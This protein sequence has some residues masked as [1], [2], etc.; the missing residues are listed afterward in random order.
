[1]HIPYHQ[2]AVCF[3]DSVAM[4]V[5]LVGLEIPLIHNL[6]QIARREKLQIFL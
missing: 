5:E 3:C 4:G 1:M 6:D 2:S